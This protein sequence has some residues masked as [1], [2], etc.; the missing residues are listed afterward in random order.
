MSKVIGTYTGI[1]DVYMK[2]CNIK[3]QIISVP[4]QKNKIVMTGHDPLKNINGS[5][6]SVKKLFPT[7]H[8]N[9]YGVF[10]GYQSRGSYQGGPMYNFKNHI[11]LF[12]K[13]EKHIDKLLKFL[14]KHITKKKVRRT[15]KKSKKGGCGKGGGKKTHGISKKDKTLRIKYKK[16]SSVDCAKKYPKSRDKTLKCLD[17]KE[18]DLKSL[19]SEFPEEMKS[20]KQE[21]KDYEKKFT[22]FMKEANNC[23]KHSPDMNKIKKCAKEVGKKYGSILK[24][25]ELTQITYNNLRDKLNRIIDHTQKVD[26]GELGKLNVK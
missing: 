14:E 23:K 11:A 3:I 13:D 4:K 19:E 24:D 12:S 15:K 7:D 20:F 16:I 10:I 25:K 2:K 1:F 5:L 6:L 22:I 18:K 17:Q 8:L 26:L 9:M 21:I